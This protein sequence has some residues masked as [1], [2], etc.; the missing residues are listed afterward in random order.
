MEIG[1]YFN[2]E[3]GRSE[4]AALGSNY[5]GLNSGRH[6][7]EY[8]LRSMPGIKKIHIP[9]FTCDVILE[10][11]NTLQI[12]CQYYTINQ[13]LEIDWNTLEVAK[14]EL[15]IYT[16]YFGIKDGYI[17]GT[18]SKY[19]LPIIIDNAQALFSQ[20]VSFFPS[21]YSPRKFVGIPDGGW[22]YLPEEYENKE[23]F[24]SLEYDVSWD[25]CSHL[26]KRIELEAKE[27]HRDF[28]ENSLKLKGQPVKKMS[29]LTQ[30]LI[31]PIDFTALSKKRLENFNFLDKIL[32][33]HNGL[34]IDLSEGAIP[35]VYP[36]LIEGDRRQTL[37]DN[38]IFVA[39]Y[40]PNVFQWC[41]SGQF[42]Y[43]LCQ[44]LLPLPIDQRYG[45]EEMKQI[46]KV[47]NL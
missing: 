44:H 24:R 13:D 39:T 34:K 15:L 31:E 5:L 27:G 8:I 2:L 14:D 36:L 30:R 35:M 12:P 43:Y 6:A 11:I 20:P 46:L 19:N 47:L 25:R 32:R 33:P 23:L 37:I 45:L 41:Q 9:Y 26:L 10:P 22:L 40:W 18:L 17:H 4:G 16:N 3:L 1:G 21:F 38:K 7:L 28:K 42:E 29:I